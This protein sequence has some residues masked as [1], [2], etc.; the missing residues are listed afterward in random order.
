MYG[1]IPNPISTITLFRS[2][3]LLVF[4]HSF[5]QVGLIGFLIVIGLS[6]RSAKATEKEKAVQ[7]SATEPTPGTPNRPETPI[8]MKVGSVMTPDG[9]RSARLAKNRRKEE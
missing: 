8:A 1:F 2:S 4:I 5:L 6:S 9:R 7:F 3:L